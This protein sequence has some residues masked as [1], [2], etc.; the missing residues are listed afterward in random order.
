MDVNLRKT[1]TDTAYI[2]VGVG[3]LGFQQAQVRRRDAIARASALRR[4]ARGTLKQQTDKIKT[5]TE[6]CAGNLADFG[7][8]IGST[9][10]DTVSET[11]T[12]TV[13]AVGSQVKAGVDA[14]GTQVKASAE[15]MGTADPRSW[16][17]PVVGDIRVRVE[18]VVEQL[19][20]ITLPGTVSALPDQVSKVIEVG[21]NRVQGRFGGTSEGT[22]PTRTAASGRS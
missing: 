22:I 6:G 9:V 18:P 14:V 21:R 19:R 2:V 17:D 15:R 4:D 7:S 20:T 1:A 8:S 10:T 16:V 3:V 5:R 12:N 13:G 11:V